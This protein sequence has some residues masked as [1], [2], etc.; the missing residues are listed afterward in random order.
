MI[1]I[2]LEPIKLTAGQPNQLNV[3]LSNTSQETV[4]NLVCKLDLPTNITLLKGNTKIEILQIAPG[5]RL[6][7][8]LQVSP[9]STGT[10]VL[11]SSNFSYRDGSGKSHRIKDLR[12]E[13]NIVE[14]LPPP[15]EANIKVKLRDIELHLNQWE[16]LQGEILNIGL[17][18]LRRIVVKVVGQVKCD[19]DVHLG[20]LPKGKKVEFSISVY[21]LESGNHVPASVEVTYTDVIGRTGFR[22]IRTPL[23][24][25]RAMS[26]IPTSRR[27]ILILSANPKGTNP[28]RL[29]EEIRGIK[30]GLKRSKYR[31]L[32]QVET[33]EA[34]RVEDI[35]R[36]M[37]DHEP[38]IVHFCGH[39][40]GEEGLVFED[41]TGQVKLVSAEALAGLFSLFAEKLDC[42]LLNACYSELQAKEISRHI[43]YVIGMS[44]K[45]GDQA[46]IAFAVGFYDA[47]GADRGV[48]FAY[49]LGCNAIQMQGI[50]EH[51]TPIIVN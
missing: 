16:K 23:R 22:K 8:I 3:W 41:V 12:C 39:G 37:L 43:N 19:A 34:V 2:V 24:V 11:T 49:R 50:P 32:F 13:I 45:I 26:D 35:R 31:D 10:W 40:G 5:Q 48:D 29:D 21:T 17:V 46:A 51:L 14:S 15:P 28:L 1:H 20:I 7:H 33:A 36:A 44:Q 6:N 25:T 4:T 47:L 27:T 42:V 18:D 30:E 38:N 9:K